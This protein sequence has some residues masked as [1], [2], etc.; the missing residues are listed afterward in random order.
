MILLFA[1]HLLV[2]NVVI[3]AQVIDRFVLCLHNGRVSLEKLKVQPNT[4]VLMVKILSRDDNYAELGL[5][6]SNKVTL[7]WICMFVSLISREG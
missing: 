4:Y 3:P 1:F 5:L 7:T 2:E 6:I